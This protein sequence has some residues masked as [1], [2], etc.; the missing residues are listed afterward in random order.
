MI[1]PQKEE[2]ITNDQILEPGMYMVSISLDNDAETPEGRPAVIQESSSFCVGGVLDGKG[3]PTN[4][5]K[6]EL[7]EMA[8]YE[9][10]SDVSK[11][12]NTKGSVDVPRPTSKFEN[13][14]NFKFLKRFSPLFVKPQPPVKA[15]EVMS[16]LFLNL[17]EFYLYTSMVV[18]LLLMVVGFDAFGFSTLIHLLFLI[19]TLTVL[20][21]MFITHKAT[22]NDKK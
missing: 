14:S 11:A 15:S 9:P 22:K 21:L 6:V 16:I 19:V 18:L 5:P 2:T 4:S 10:C 13:A 20:V 8:F 3:T 12:M 1:I 17:L 7:S